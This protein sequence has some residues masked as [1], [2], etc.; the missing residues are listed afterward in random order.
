MKTYSFHLIIAMTLVFVLII[1]N[2]CQWQIIYIHINV[3]KHLR[4]K[5]EC[6]EACDESC[7]SI[8]DRGNSKYELRIKEAMHIQWVAPTLNKQNISLKMTF[9]V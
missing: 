3:F 4:A 1:I 2:Y 7:F 9:V 5:P 6:K 8:I